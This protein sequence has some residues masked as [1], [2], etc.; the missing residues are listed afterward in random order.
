MPEI[1]EIIQKSFSKLY[2]KTKI[3]PHKEKNFSLYKQLTVMLNYFK[4]NF[5][6]LYLRDCLVIFSF[7]AASVT[8]LEFT[9]ALLISSFS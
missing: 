5:S 7:F 1:L 2:E 8:F 3:F 9:N 6:I 4:L